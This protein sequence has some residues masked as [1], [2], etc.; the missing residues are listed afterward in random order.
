[1]TSNFPPLYRV[2][3][4][5]LTYNLILSCIKSSLTLPDTPLYGAYEVGGVQGG[6]EWRDR[7]T[8]RLRNETWWRIKRGLEG[9]EE[10]RWLMWR[11]L[12]VETMEDG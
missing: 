1:M 2:P 6:R 7:R 3:C 8:K 4:N 12:H 10:V 5:P 9:E 11:L